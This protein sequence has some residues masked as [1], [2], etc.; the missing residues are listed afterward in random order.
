M[1]YWAN[2]I[3]IY[4]IWT[5]Y[6][7]NKY[8]VPI[9]ITIEKSISTDVEN[10]RITSCLLGSYIRFLKKQFAVATNFSFQMIFICKVHLLSSKFCNMHYWNYS[11]INN[12]MRRIHDSFD[13]PYPELKFQHFILQRY[14]KTKRTYC[15]NAVCFVFWRSSWILELL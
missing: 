6:W 9:V 2:N 12:S 4:Y 8:L 10:G 7:A 3:C 14:L 5:T 11:N 1:W 15:K 13:L